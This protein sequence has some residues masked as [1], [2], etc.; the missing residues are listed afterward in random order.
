[1]KSS[2]GVCRATSQRRPA[3]AR[4]DGRRAALLRAR[5]PGDASP[6]R[7]PRPAPGGRQPARRATGGAAGPGDR[8][9]GR[10]APAGSSAGS[11]W[12]CWGRSRS[13]RCGSRR[14]SYARAD[15]GAVRGHAVRRRAGPAALGDRLA[16]PC[17]RRSGPERA[18]AAAPHGPA[19]GVAQA[20]RPRAGPGGY[21]DAVEWRWVERRGRPSPAPAWCGCARGRPGRRASTMTPVQ[22]LMTCV[23]SASGRLR[24]ARPRAVGVPEHRADRARAARRR[25]ASGSAWTRETTLGTRQR[26]ASPPP[27]CT[28]SAGWS[29]GRPRRCWSRRASDAADRAARS[30]RPG[31]TKYM[32]PYGSSGRSCVGPVPALPADGGAQHLE[33]S[34]APDHQLLGEPG[35][36][37]GRPRRLPRRGRPGRSSKPKARSSR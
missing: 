4:H 19:D 21:L 1:M 24:R 28:T 2:P 12:S 29:R 8:A 37:A 3:A 6:P 7:R 20:I 30:E 15:G 14:P 27:G 23:D 9:A 33:G 26:R 22:R 13:G 32:T 10:S 31:A 34:S 35:I 36:H 17:L 16:V 25:S 11:R 5:R 18:G